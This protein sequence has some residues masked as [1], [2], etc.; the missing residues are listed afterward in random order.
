MIAKDAKMTPIS[1]G[2]LGT[3]RIGLERVIPAM[4]QMVRDH[5]VSGSQSFGGHPGC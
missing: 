4:R 2:V 5:P 1:W 3:A